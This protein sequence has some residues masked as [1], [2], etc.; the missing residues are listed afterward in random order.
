MILKRIYTFCKHLTHP[1]VIV[2]MKN[3][4]DF[5]NLTLNIMFYKNNNINIEFCC[6]YI[7]SYIKILISLCSKYSFY[8]V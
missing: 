2:A 4:L 5:M 6:Y 1:Q 3:C 7:T 8:I